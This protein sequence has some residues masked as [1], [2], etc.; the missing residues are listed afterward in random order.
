MISHRDLKP[1]NVL[2]DKNFKVK[3]ADF[4]MAA[5]VRP[6]DLQATSCGY[7]SITTLSHSLFNYSLGSLRSPHFA[8][9]EVIA[10]GAYDGKIA[11]LWSVGVI[12]YT[13]LTVRFIL[14]AGKYCVLTQT[15]M[16]TGLLALSPR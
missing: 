7:A 1:E 5:I 10:G 11:D 15:A 3:I 13:L 12:L 4:G 6:G 16:C 8:A 2:L 14:L 9:P